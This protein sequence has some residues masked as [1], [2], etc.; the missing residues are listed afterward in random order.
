MLQIY[1]KLYRRP[2]FHKQFAALVARLERETCSLTVMTMEGGR[3]FRTP[4]SRIFWKVASFSTTR[5]KR[6]VELTSCTCGTFSGTSRPGDRDGGE[7][8]VLYCIC[9]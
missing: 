4:L 9:I 1:N 7:T 8:T 6:A 3:W 2:A 5:M